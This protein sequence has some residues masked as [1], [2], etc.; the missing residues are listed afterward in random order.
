MLSTLYPWIKALHVMAVISWMAGLF[1]LPRL[2]V[3]HAEK[4]PAGSAASEMLKEM[5]IKL[6]RV[7]MNPAMIVTWICGALMI[8]A[9]P[10]LLEQPWMWVKLVAVVAMSGFHG[11]LAGCRRSFAEDRNSRTGR[12][13]RMANEV[14]TVLMIVIVIMVIV[15]PF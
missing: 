5:E 14:P 1:Y 2:F 12:T 8:V 6:L 4:A 11:W 13:Y 3:H 10:G 7:I 9:A 15:Q